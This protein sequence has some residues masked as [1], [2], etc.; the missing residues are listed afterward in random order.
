MEEALK[1]GQVVEPASDMHACAMTMKRDDMDQ[2]AWLTAR[3]TTRP[4]VV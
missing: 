1:A 3:T 2:S 4:A